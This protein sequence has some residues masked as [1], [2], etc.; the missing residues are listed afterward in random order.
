[1]GKKK[2]GASEWE[3]F[4][5]DISIFELNTFIEGDIR[6][7]ENIRING[8]LNGNCV[9]E[10]MIVISPSG[11]VTGDISGK[12][13]LIKGVVFGKVKSAG[14]IHLTENSKV[15]GDCICQSIIID[16]GAFLNGYVGKDEP[17]QNKYSKTNPEK[18][19]SKSVITESNDIKLN[20]ENQDILDEDNSNQLW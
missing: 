19:L 20:K 13:I 6:S 10:G 17:V 2:K 8:V 18:E 3:P 1:M 14:K 4:S 9:S 7:K 11:C 12:T 15:E 5:P 16:T